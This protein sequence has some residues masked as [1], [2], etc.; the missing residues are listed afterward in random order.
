MQ[1]WRVLKSPGDQ[2]QAETP[3]V[4]ILRQEVLAAPADVWLPAFGKVAGALPLDELKAATGE[5]VLYLQGAIDVMEGGPVGLALQ[6]SEPLAAWLDVTSFDPA[7]PLVTDLTAGTHTLT[8]RV[9]VGDQPSP[10]LRAEFSKPAGSAAQFI[11][12]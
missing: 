1:R 5:S 12:Q 11:V 9:T 4:E 7:Q 10:E 6:S 8:V 2:L 3:N